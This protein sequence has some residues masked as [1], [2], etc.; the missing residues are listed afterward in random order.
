MNKQTSDIE[1]DIKTKRFGLVFEEH[2]ES[3]NAAGIAMINK[4]LSLIHS[5]TFEVIVVFS[6]IS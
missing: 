5:S 3:T 2:K 4:S 1:K 6:P